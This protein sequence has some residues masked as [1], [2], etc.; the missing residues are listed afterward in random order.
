M[1]LSKLF[2]PSDA[3]LGMKSDKDKKPY[4]ET[5][6]T[7]TSLSNCAYFS[8]NPL[9]TAINRNSTDSVRCSLNVS[10]FRNF[11]FE[12]DS[13][14]LDAQL[15]LLNYITANS[16]IRFA[17]VTYSGGAS[18][19][20]IVSVSDTLPFDV[21][22]EAGIAAYS[23]AWRA[24]SMELN[25][26]AANYLATVPARLF[27]PACK[28]PARL[29]RTPGAIRPDTGEVQSAETSFSGYM[30]AD[31]IVSIMQKHNLAESTETRSSVEQA[32]EMQLA[33]LEQLLR[34]NDLVYLRNKLEWPQTWAGSANMYPEVFKLTLWCIDALGVP[35]STLLSYLGD[36]VFPVLRSS[37]YPRDASIAVTNAYL[38]KG[39][40]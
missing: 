26:I 24:L 2:L 21:H 35:Y 29:S 12:C 30:K 38:W 8:I 28:D 22:K 14:P 9:D 27:D 11:L 25:N 40:L 20:A 6:L 18:Y 16:A 10:A 5:W 17:T 15:G 36:K 7:E 39:L 31:Y 23:R 37:G 19:H 4:C 32:T 1:S 13:L 33:E 34:R 3:V